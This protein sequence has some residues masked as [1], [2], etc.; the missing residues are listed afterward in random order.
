M[1]L[2]RRTLF[3]LAAA[4]GTAGVAGAAATSRASV[5]PAAR[6]ARGVLV[7]TTRCVGCR[8]CE[9]ACAEANALAGPE[10]PGDDT[11]FASKRSTSP[12]AYTVVQKGSLKSPAG[13][14]RFAKTQCMHCVQPACASGCVVKALEKTASGPVVYHKD[15]PHQ[16]QC[17]GY[18]ELRNQVEKGR[19]LKLY[20]QSLLQR[21][22]ENAVAGGV[23]EI[24]E[25]DGVFLRQRGSLARAPVE[26]AGNRGDKHDRHGC[27]QLPPKARSPLAGLDAQLD[28]VQVGPDLAGVLIPQPAVFLH[29]LLNDLFQLGWHFGVQAARWGR[30]A[31]QDFLVQNFRGGAAECPLPSRHFV[32]HQTK[33]KQVAPGVQLFFS[34][35]LRR[36]VRQCSHRYTGLAQAQLLRGRGS[37]R[38]GF[39]ASNSPPGAVVHR[40]EE[41]TSELQ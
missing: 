33:G 9:A 19:L 40:S 31:I 7:D 13:E 20:R 34:H 22:V 17:I 26:T 5:V 35:L 36:H 15:P 4:A 38:S 23:G 30:R 29:R 25:D 32:E 3:K 21:F 1:N 39:A 18:L 12:T 10:K 27:Q 8:A 6:N 16:L 41:H 2:N 14:D 24:R 11:V 28:S 37:R